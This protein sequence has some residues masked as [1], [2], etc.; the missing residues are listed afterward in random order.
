MAKV[1]IEE[2]HLTAIGDAIRA[3]TGKSEL[4]N[5]TAMPTEIEAI[6]TGGGDIE[7]IVL[8]GDCSYACA[9]A[10]WNGLF[11]MVSTQ[12][13]SSASC[14]FQGNQDIEKIPFD[15]NLAPRIETLGSIFM[16][17]TSLKEVPVI[18]GTL[19][20]P[21]GN[22]SGTVAMND[23]FGSCANLRTIPY[24]YFYRF[25]GDAFWEGCKKYQAARTNIFKGCYSLRQ[26]PD[27]RMLPSNTNAYYN[28]FYYGTFTNCY[29][30]DEIRD[31]P[32]QDDVTFTS[33]MFQTAFDNCS[34]ISN[35]MFE[36]NEDGTPKVANWSNQTIDLS[37][38]Y[39]AGAT[40]SSMYITYY[41]SG[42][43]SDKQVYD[44]ATYA[45]LKNDPDWWASSWNYSRYNHDSAVNTI[46][47]LP[48]C[49]SGSGNTIKFVK[50]SGTKTDGGAIGNLTEEEIAVAAAK[51]W[52]VSLTSLL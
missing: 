16:R 47:S 1:F 27:T 26:L 30:L 10:A 15:I 33:N 29:S 8:A 24:D 36:T 20:A 35:L 23:F 2:S 28:S 39:G 17:C 31:L 7:P 45:A 5:P 34:R 37:K 38:N 46:N 6:Q 19:N 41:N 9:N 49:S 4:L 40:N 12:N 32:V 11:P 52:T 18:K 22:Y 42:I 3:K 14:M 25:G 13:V 50:E 21:T 44:D 48:D 43:T 51:G